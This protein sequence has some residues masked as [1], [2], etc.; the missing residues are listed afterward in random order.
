MNFS[1]YKHRKKKRNRFHC[2]LLRDQIESLLVYIE[3]SDNTP[4]ILEIKIVD[5]LTL[6]APNILEGTQF[7]SGAHDTNIE[8]T[9][10]SYRI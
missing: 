7:L 6:K 9:K 2:N 3:N 8:S 1:K 10:P 5:S 4:Y